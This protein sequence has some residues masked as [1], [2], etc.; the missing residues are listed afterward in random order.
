MDKPRKK[1]IKL[2]THESWAIKTLRVHITN[3]LGLE[4]ICGKN[5]IKCEMYEEDNFYLIYNT[6]GEK[7]KM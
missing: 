1:E 2:M 4:A 5:N 6:L 3:S 7:Q